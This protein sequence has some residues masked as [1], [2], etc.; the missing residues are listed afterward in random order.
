VY[1]PSPSSRPTRAA[2]KSLAID[3]LKLGPNPTEQMIALKR[4]SLGKIE[5]SPAKKST[6]IKSVA[7]KSTAS[8]EINPPLVGYPGLG[9]N[10]IGK[11]AKK[12]DP[13]AVDDDTMC[14][15]SPSSRSNRAPRKSLSTDMGPNLTEQMIAL[16]RSEMSPAKISTPI[17]SV[18]LK[19]TPSKEI[20]PPLVGHPGLGNNE[21]FFAQIHSASVKYEEIIKQIQ[22]FKGA[23]L[24]VLHTPCDWGALEVFNLVM[25]IRQ[26]NRKAGV[27]TFSILVG[28]GLESV[29]LFH[30]ALSR[31]TKHV[32]FVVFER[33]DKNLEQPV[34]LLRDVNSFFLLA[35]FFAGCE[36]EDQSKVTIPQMVRSGSTTCFHT[37]SNEDLENNI[38]HSLSE[39]G[40]WIMDLYCGRRELSLAAQKMG[41]NAV[42]IHDDPTSLVVL[43]EKA[44]AIAKHHEP[45]FRIGTDGVILKLN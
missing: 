4:R 26:L 25:N 5:F 14:F 42:A 45:S 33:E 37:T 7:L 24:T 40:D 35:Y 27:T 34:Q 2:R 9:K 11:K 12:N 30:E 20:N 22:S 13:N 32:Q 8:K 31:Q 29:H 23:N 15:A 38:V 16:K 41:R 19:A 21:I 17:K 6:P 18:A 36:N 44:S 10:E 43:H 39:K 1:F 28:S 3:C